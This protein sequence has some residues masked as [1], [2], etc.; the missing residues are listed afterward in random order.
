M[1]HLRVGFVH[2]KSDIATIVDAFKNKELDVLIATTVIEVGVNVPNA[3]IITILNAERFG[4]AQLHQLRGRV[5]RGSF[6]SYCYLQSANPTPDGQKKL[7][8]MTE[9]TDGFYLS[10]VDL[11]LRGAGNLVGDSQSG[12]EKS[13]ML[14]MKYPQLFEIIQRE[15][16]EIFN[17]EE[18]LAHYKR[19]FRE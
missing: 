15:I 11:S 14:L 2:G 8:A 7:Q 18:R 9:S 19:L 13:F 4:L 16:E 1:K 17:D 10:Q 5:G 3:T 6:A 12:F